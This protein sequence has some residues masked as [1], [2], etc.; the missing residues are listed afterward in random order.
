MLK[1]IMSPL[2]RISLGLVMVTISVILISDLLGIMPD[3]RKAEYEAR[4]IIAE[5][6]AIQLSTAVAENMQRTVEVTLR[7]V[8]GRNENI[9]SS[10]IRDAH[11]YLLFVIADH[12]KQWT[13]KPDDQSTLTQVHVP[14]YGK[15]GHWGTAELIFKDDF[16]TLS[17][18]NSLFGVI[19]LVLVSGFIGY[20]LFLKNTLRELD[21]NAV[22][23]ERVHEA[24]DTLVEGLLII[25]RKGVI[26]FSNEA[27]AQR[28]GLPPNVLIGKESASL[29]WRLADKC[30]TNKELPWFCLMEGKELEDNTIIK[31]LAGT[32]RIYTF[33]VHATVISADNGVTRGA[34]ITF[35]D[36]SNIEEKNDELRRTLERF[37]ES[38]R[39]ISRQNQEL[40]LLATRDS[41]TNVLNRR[42]LFKGFESLFAAAQEED[43]NLSCVM[44]DIDHFKL[45]N[46]NFGHAVGDEVIK[47]MAKIL[48]E[49]SR[50]SDLVG[51]YGGEEFCLV[52]PGV[53]RDSAVTVSERIRIAIEASHGAKF[54]DA[55]KITSS[56]GVA[57]IMDG[58]KDI[59]ELVDQADRALYKAKKGGRNCVVSWTKAGFGGNVIQADPPLM[60]EHGS[61]Q[62]LNES[63]GH[64]DAH[65]QGGLRFEDDNVNDSVLLSRAIIKEDAEY[66]VGEFIQENAA[67]NQTDRA[68]LFDR[69]DQAIRRASRNKTHVAVM[70][71]SIQQLQRVY[72]T[73]GFS[74]GEKFTSIVVARLQKVVRDTDTATQM[75]QVELRYA[76]SRLEGNEIVLLLTDLEKTDSVTVIMRRLFAAIND[77]I[78]VNGLEVFLGVDI[79]LSLYPADGDGADALLCQSASAMHEAENCVGRNKFQYYSEEIS[80]YSVR[81]LRLDA[82]LHRAL[83]RDELVL[84]YQAK[85][86]LRSGAYVGMEALLRWNHPRLGLVPPVD[87]IPIAEQSGLIDQ[88]S[89][90]VI[91][92]VCK[93]VL[94]WQE[95]G[96]GMQKVAVNLSPVN[97]KNPELPEIIF[98]LL[99]DAGIPPGMLEIEI[100]E[101]VV[102]QNINTVASIL[103]QLDAAGVQITLDDFGTGYSS[104]SYLKK[105]PVSK[106]KIDRSFISDFVCQSNDVAIVNAVI[107]MGHSLGMLVVAEGVETE[108]QLYMLKDM[109]CDQI[110]GYYISKPIP[111]EEVSALLSRY[112]DPQRK[113]INVGVHGIESTISQY[114]NGMF[115][116]LNKYEKD[117]G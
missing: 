31:L 110:Q 39:E 62:K 67:S 47:Y 78:E 26:V 43:Q 103:K 73:M 24:L 44:I 42:S 112:A 54:T 37:E 52:L 50:P 115:G 104:L 16:K 13:L 3:S 72:K 1:F 69:L 29:S 17:L 2:S 65:A 107:A 116:V 36:I 46:D 9:L 86:D 64:V 19:L 27:F 63:G 89:Q 59:A 111:A 81:Q 53:D 32:G 23:P 70:S 97:F 94:L 95:S 6:L 55:I 40:I 34:L 22:I 18:R 84:H 83:R 21:P 93:Q 96:F 45:V 101:S 7:S 100:T 4:R 41:L 85:V 114:N 8:V 87:F 12:D 10:G 99:N 66:V 51:R 49:F 108:E 33:S 77:S 25:D 102:F 28:T 30:T 60:V 82:D 117:A 74:I 90:S 80:Q 106:V 14:I 48:I 109:Q 105:F 5:S 68:L 58:A 20:L 11:G 88:V 61:A 76:L 75:D 71:I 38:Q 79:G 92:M 57:D 56:F 35:D 15:Q 113:I 91:S 98:G